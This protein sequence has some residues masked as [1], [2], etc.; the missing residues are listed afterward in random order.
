MHEIDSYDTAVVLVLD[1]A[2]IPSGRP[3]PDAQPLPGDE[4]APGG[5]ASVAPGSRLL[6]RLSLL[7]A[8]DIPRFIAAD[9]AAIPAILADP[10]VAAGVASWWGGLDAEHRETLIRDDPAARGQPR[11]DPAP[12][13][14]R[15]QPFDAH[16]HDELSC[17][18]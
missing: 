14:R 17:A 3:L 13:A 10:P 6:H 4:F 9:Q 7:S 8:D 12:G 15:R 18:T 5:P 11:R 1:S 16:E 2:A